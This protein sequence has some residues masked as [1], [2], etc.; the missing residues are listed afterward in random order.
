ML[1][2]GML[3][4]AGQHGLLVADSDSDDID[5]LQIVKCALWLAA[6]AFAMPQPE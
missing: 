4:R 6:L 1:G 5:E 2:A 3:S